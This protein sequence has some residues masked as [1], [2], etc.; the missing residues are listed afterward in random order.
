MEERPML[1]VHN[2][3]VS[4]RSGVSIVRDISFKLSQGQILGILG[5]SGSGKST[6][7]RAL[8]GY[9]QPGVVIAAGSVMI[10]HEEMVGRREDDLRK[11]RGRLVSYVPQNPATSLNPSGRIG[12]QIEDRV[13]YYPRADHPHLVERALE[14]AQ[15]PVDPEF[16]RRFP[17][18]LSGGQQQ[19]AMIAAALVGN[20]SLVVLD[21]PTTGLDMITQSRL[22]RE[23]AQLRAESEMS[24]IYISHDIAAVASIADFVLV[25]YAGLIM[26]YG[27]V[28]EVLQ[29]PRHPYTRAL[30]ESIPDL[31]TSLHLEALPG[32]AI[33]VGAWPR[34]CPFSPRCSQTT[35]DCTTLLPQ[36][37]HVFSGHRVRCLNWRAT[38]V[39]KRLIRSAEPTQSPRSA[40]IDV[41]SLKAV[42]RTHAEQIVAVDDVS[43]SVGHG[44]CVA[45]VGES[46][47]GK[48]TIARCVVGL[49][50][51]DSGS[52]RLH[53][54][55]LPATAA[56][57]DLEA[58]RRIQIIFQNPDDS[59]NPRHLIGSTVMR[60]AKVL[61]GLGGAAAKAEMFEALERVRLPTGVATRYPAELSGGERQ[62]VAIARALTARPEVLICDE[63][64]SS[65]DVSVQGAVLDLLGELQAQLGV[66]ILFISHDLGV[67]ASIADRVLILKQGLIREAGAVNA[68]FRN[69]TDS[70]TQ[71][72]IES[73]PRLDVPLT[74]A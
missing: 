8:L 44:E 10:A 36:E 65:L 54:R 29:R 32:T 56:R 26:E 21:E 46:G 20:P 59:L 71:Q 43:F 68:V 69:P 35:S 34:G 38:P 24:L 70:Y 73:A 52:V 25:L 1:V 14:R 13:A 4:L 47:S 28:E 37:E 16:R 66:A 2:L 33:G 55:I 72:L 57:R 61:R 63:I 58:R 31:T 64:T 62:R 30:I 45:L 15:L 3:A 48:T 9:V 60:P 74:T 27:S 5:E 11:L 50:S 6:L 53:G 18:Q 23:I 7:G 51:P 67:V 39:P 40:I 42:H 19:R 41:A 12:R 17:H 22:L 49:H